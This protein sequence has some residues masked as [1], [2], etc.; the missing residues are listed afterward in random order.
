MKIAFVG[1]GNMAAAL[2]GGVIGQGI[3]PRHVLAVDPNDAARERCV[4]AFGIDAC[5]GVD[6]RIAT[7]DVIVLAVK[8]QMLKDVCH[9]LASELRSQ[10]IISVA[11]GVRLTD[12]CQWLGGYTQIVRAMP[13]TPALI[14]KGATGAFASAEMG[15][16]E[17]STAS[18]L[19]E[20]V[21][22]VVWFDD[23]AMLNA[24]TAISG[25][26][27][28]YVFYFIECLQEAAQALGLSE[29][30]GQALAIATFSGAA[31]LAAASSES[32]AVLRDRVTSKGGTTAAALSSFEASGVRAAIIRGALAANQRSIELGDELG[33][34]SA[35]K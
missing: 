35:R 9:R 31:E 13:N 3:D 29:A 11:A 18:K 15:E 10:L 33:V 8:P 27:P 14:G 4:T 12:L 22:T 21:G 19:L 7:Y 17:R 2:I 24:V 23:E 26:G 34:G 32:V 25:S 30:Q 20:S 28:A 1:A 6:A 16:K 5:D